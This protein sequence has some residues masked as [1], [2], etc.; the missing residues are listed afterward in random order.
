MNVVL[1]GRLEFTGG[2]HC[3]GVWSTDVKKKAID[4]MPFASQMALQADLV[5]GPACSSACIGDTPL[6]V[7]T[8]LIDVFADSPRRING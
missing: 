8:P 1:E 3:N 5:C 2:W 6:A 7:L 4:K